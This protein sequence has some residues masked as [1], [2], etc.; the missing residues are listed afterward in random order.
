ML[1]EGE[2]QIA[3]SPH[4]PGIGLFRSVSVF[5]LPFYSWRIVDIV[6]VSY[7]RPAPDL[8][9]TR[10]ALP[11]PMPLARHPFPAAEQVNDRRSPD[12]SRDSGGNP[13]RPLHASP[14]ISAS[15]HPGY[16]AADQ[17][18]TNGASV[19]CVFDVCFA[20]R[21]LS[22]DQLSAFLQP[23]NPLATSSPVAEFR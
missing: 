7:P 22:C 17:E 3:L 18:Y 14:R 20:G 10:K 11:P 15:L 2:P 6:L 23:A 4:L 5:C 19:S 8:P 9:S 21:P 13:G 1:R 12:N 16:L